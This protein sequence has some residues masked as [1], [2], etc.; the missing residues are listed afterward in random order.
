MYTI[1]LPRTIIGHDSKAHKLSILGTILDKTIWTEDEKIEYKERLLKK[2]NP[3]NVDWYIHRDWVEEYIKDI[4]ECRLMVPR[5]KEYTIS[6][7]KI[8]IITI[9]KDQVL[10]LKDSRN[11]RRY[12]FRKIGYPEHDP[13]WFLTNILY[14]YLE[15]DTDK[16]L[17]FE[18][19]L[20]DE[21]ITINDD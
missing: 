16:P 20:K 17:R 8:H 9:T 5:Y 4:L 18:V 12:F 19:I 2:E 1:K 14:P 3:N 11:A 21:S 10:K 7:P 6:V 15:E 13:D